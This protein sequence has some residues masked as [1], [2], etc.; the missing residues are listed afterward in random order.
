M[1]DECGATGERLR[2]ARLPNLRGAQRR[3]KLSLRII[4]SNKR[5]AVNDQRLTQRAGNG[6]VRFEV[7]DLVCKGRAVPVGVN[8]GLTD[9]DN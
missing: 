5:A 3:K 4:C 1:Q 2:A 7:R 9:R 6:N 8:A